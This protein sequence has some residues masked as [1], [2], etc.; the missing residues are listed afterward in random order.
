MRVDP[1]NDFSIDLLVVCFTRATE[2]GDYLKAKEELA[3]KIKSIVVAAGGRFAFP[4]RSIYIEIGKDV[5]IETAKDVDI[6]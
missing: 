3:P 6:K 1:L 5:D 4:S 2:F